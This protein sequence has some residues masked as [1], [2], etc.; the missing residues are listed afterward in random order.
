MQ[1]HSKSDPTLSDIVFKN[2]MNLVWTTLKTTVLFMGVATHSY[3]L[4]L[5]P[6]LITKTL[7]KLRNGLSLDGTK[8]Q[9]WMV[10]SM[11][12]SLGIQDHVWIQARRKWT[13]F[14]KNKLWTIFPR[15]PWSKFKMT[16]FKFYSE[17]MSNFRWSFDSTSKI[18][19]AY[20]L[21]GF[22]LA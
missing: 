21:R 11:N 2:K 18:N 10:R 16:N 7:R 9:N 14:I 12:P 8:I 20:I 17:K 1:S 19:F 15:H 22:W 3:F 6:K 4:R 13:I 5:R